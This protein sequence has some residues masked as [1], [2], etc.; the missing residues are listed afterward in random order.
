MLKDIDLK[1]VFND[2]FSEPQYSVWNLDGSLIIKKDKMYECT[3]ISCSSIKELFD[4][5]FNV[6]NNPLRGDWNETTERLSL[7]LKM[8]VEEIYN[9]IKVLYS[10]YLEKHPE[11]FI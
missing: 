4:A 2:L 8:T 5:Y 1:T 3:Y 7:E 10:E 6:F 11:Y 9:N